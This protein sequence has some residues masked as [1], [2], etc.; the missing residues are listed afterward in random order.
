[1]E[2]KRVIN[3]EEI[4]IKLTSEELA[5]AN[6]EFVTEFMRNKLIEDFGVSEEKADELS[7]AAYDKYCKGDGLTEYECIEAVVEEWAS[8]VIRTAYDIKWDTDVEDL[9]QDD[10][11]TEIIIPESII[12]EEEISNYVSNCVGFCHG[13]FKVREEKK[14]FIGTIVEYAN[15]RWYVDN[16]DENFK[17]DGEE[18]SLFLLPEKYADA[19]ENDK[20]MSS[21][22]PDEVGEW[23][24]ASLV[25]AME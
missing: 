15:K 16:T 2:I 19:D 20:L 10:L 9:D 18:T 14:E 8:S 25:K 11:P 12:D 22:N 24:Y 17:D 6:A 23:V 4:A 7:N 21:G 13:G 1:M 5:Q 3:G